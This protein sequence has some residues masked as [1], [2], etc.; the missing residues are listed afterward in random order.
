MEEA[1]STFS[2]KIILL[3]I[4]LL[5]SYVVISLA[6]HLGLKDRVKSKEAKKGMV[7]ILSFIAFAFI[8]YALLNPGRNQVEPTQTSKP[9]IDVAPLKQSK[10]PGDWSSQIV[11]FDKIYRAPDGCNN[12]KDTPSME[13]SNHRARAIKRFQS[14]WSEGEFW[15]NGKVFLNQQ[16][17]VYVNTDK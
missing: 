3:M 12:D 4:L 8:G 1:F 16:A 5:G 10:S 15:R 14:R 6:V 2:S 7:T 11:I 13:C 9:K 17:A